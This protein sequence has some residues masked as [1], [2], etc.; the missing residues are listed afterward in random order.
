MA[1]VADRHSDATNNARIMWTPRAQVAAGWHPL[2][3]RAVALPY[4]TCLPTEGAGS[5]TILS[6]AFGGTACGDEIGVTT[7]EAAIT[8]ISARRDFTGFHRGDHRAGGFL[9]V[10]A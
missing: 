4:T 6:A 10:P 2:V 8:F 9:H 3:P 5:L 1:A 7:A